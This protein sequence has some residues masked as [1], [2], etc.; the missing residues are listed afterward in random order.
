MIKHE[1]KTEKIQ[2]LKIIEKECD[3]C[4]KNE[5]F[6]DKRPIVGNSAGGITHIR[7]EFSYGSIFDAKVFGLDICDICFKKL[8]KKLKMKI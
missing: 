4:H 1:T 2:V 6:S 5:K 3:W 7:V 8:M